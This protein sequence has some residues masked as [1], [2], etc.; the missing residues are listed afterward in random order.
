MKKISFIFLM[1]ALILCFSACGKKAA[2]IALPSADKITSIEVTG[3]VEDII[4]TDKEA[5]AAII[6]KVSEAQPTSQES[7]QDVPLVDEYTRIDM[8]SD[9]EILSIFVYQKD[10]N[11]YVEQPYQGIYKTDEKTIL[12]FTDNS[13]QL[14]ETELGDRRPMVMIDGKLYYDTGKETSES[15]ASSA[16]KGKISSEVAVSEIPI[17]N[18]ESNF[19]CVGAD[20]AMYNDGVA[21]KLDNR[22]F[23][24]EVE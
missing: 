8:V 10:G 22:W 16:I 15:I 9:G 21:L 4:V 18:D 3:G 23:L 19:D 14:Q 20:Y 7:V 5:I 24:F 2:L 11:W 6:E 12:L 13:S 17:Q 1:M